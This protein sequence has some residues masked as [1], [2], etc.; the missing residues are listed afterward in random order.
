M[1]MKTQAQYVTDASGKKKA[2]ILDIKYYEKLLHTIDELEDKKAF[3][4]VVHEDSVPYA[5][6]ESRLIKSKHL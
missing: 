3:L 2:V 4:S 5:S 6:I 1:R